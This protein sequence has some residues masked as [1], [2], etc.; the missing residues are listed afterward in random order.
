MNTCLQTFRN[1]NLILL[2]LLTLNLS[3]QIWDAKDIEFP[4]P[5]QGWRVR[6]IDDNVAWT[7]GYSIGPEQGAWSY[8][9][10]ENS[11][12]KTS[13]GG[14]TW[15]TK[16]FR[17][18]GGGEGFILDV[19]GVNESIAFV[20]YYDFIAG[21]ILYRTK[22]GGETWQSN[23]GGADY[24]LDWVYFYD[25]NNGVS[26]GDAGEDGFFQFS[27]STDGGETW[28][29]NNNSLISTI[30]SSEYGISSYFAVKDS[31]IWTPT[32]YGRILHSVDKGV[33]WNVILGPVSSMTD[34]WGISVDD[35]HNLILILF[36]DTN[37]EIHMLKKNS[38]DW[39][40]ITPANNTG[41][42]VGFSAIPG[43]NTLILNF[44]TIWD[45]A[46]TYKT[47]V[48]I[49]NGSTWN[50]VSTG[51]GFKYGYIEFSSPQTGYSCEIPQSFEM[52]SNHVYKYNGSPLSGILSQNMLV[53]DVEIFPNPTSDILNITVTSETNNDYWM[54]INDINGKLIDKR[55]YNNTSM[56]KASIKTADLPAG[57]YL[58]TITSKDGVAS[59]KFIKR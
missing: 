48:S 12:Q 5:S 3:A 17:F 8:T 7:F 42:L 45:D 46:S 57:E 23:N 50:V 4:V 2:T 13:D 51:E 10:S 31:S 34:V 25:K 52:P 37:F 9:N 15:E 19:I 33:N 11:C 6:P 55:M 18:D 24:F 58:I 40:N 26:F 1:L 39:I 27:N 22:D 16:F 56:F 29:L 28:T 49:D 54:L 43:T 59:R 35:N 41:T 21:T 44:P 36:S 38:S 14:E 53:A 30:D 20:N 47:Y 32:S